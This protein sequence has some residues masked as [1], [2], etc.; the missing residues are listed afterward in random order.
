MH[1]PTY[2]DITKLDTLDKK[3]NFLI[4]ISSSFSELCMY[5]NTRWRLYYFIAS[6]IYA[7]KIGELMCQH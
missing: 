2:S 7:E 5:V 6:V 4:T 3:L 1:V